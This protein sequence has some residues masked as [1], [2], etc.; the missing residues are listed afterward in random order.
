MTCPA[1]VLE[2]LSG[3]V[4]ELRGAGLPVSTTEHI[5]A[6]SAMHHV[7]M[8]DRAALKAALAATLVKSSSH[9]AAFETAFEVYFAPRSAQD[10]GARSVPGDATSGQGD[11][12]SDASATASSAAS[13]PGAG[14]Q[15]GA[16][17]GQ[18]MS[19]QELSA[20]LLRALR[21]GDRGLSG[22]VARHAVDRYG[23]IEPGRPVG[24]TYY[25]Y[26]TLRH[27]DLESLLE[28][29]LEAERQESDL[30]ALEERLL[31]DEYRARIAVL[32]KAVEA[33][34]RRRLVHDRGAQ[35]LARSVRRQVPEDLDVMHAT[36]DELEALRKALHPLSR[37]L[38]VRLGRK[39]RHRRRGPLDFRAT[40][41]S[42][43]QTGG[44]P[45]EPR[46]R[47]P[48]PS[49]PEIFVIAD[50]SGSV[51]SFARFTLQLVHALSTQ[52]SK[53][54]S[55]VFVDGIDEVTDLLE[56]TEDS[57]HVLERVITE[58]DVVWVDGHSDYGHALREFDRRWGSD[59]T[60]RSTVLVLGDA[61]N[62]YHESAAWVLE[63]L[64]RQARHVYWLNPEPRQYWGSGD[65]IVDE[66]AVHCDAVVEC[67]T[68]RQLERFV[69][70]L[71]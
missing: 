37:K 42:S 27:L 15:P 67:R 51:A 11:A 60:S 1:R 12:S 25:L 41:R 34:I 26:R 68:L 57:A 70:E 17:G 69:G 64:Q 48:R 61:R 66:Y 45:V 30:T 40:L 43:L 8:E 46:F 50:V 33:E 7:P 65:S 58:A 23:A 62:N 22:A 3:F 2:L 28:R 71:A 24:G 52:F 31:A 16:G 56:R 4:D 59:V 32:R 63:E 35:A 44:V 54:R 14:D 49:K 38:A 39:R 21:T 53:V 55:F 18:A 20:L 29:L 47:H 9:W 36:R 10:A 19:P 13:T 6:A 5:D